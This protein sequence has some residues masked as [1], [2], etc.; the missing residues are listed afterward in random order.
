[1]RLVVLL[2]YFVLLALCVPLGFA[3]YENSRGLYDIIRVGSEQPPIMDNPAKLRETEALS[4][5]LSN[6]LGASRDAVLC[7]SEK[8]INGRIA[9]E[10]PVAAIHKCVQARA[11]DLCYTRL[12]LKGDVDATVFPIKHPYRE[13]LEGRQVIHMKASKQWMDKETGLKGLT[14]SSLGMLEEKLKQLSATK[15][16]EV[17]PYSEVIKALITRLEKFLDDQSANLSRDQAKEVENYLTKL[18]QA[19]A[20]VK[21]ADD[22]REVAEKQDTS[23]EDIKEILRRHQTMLKDKG[24]LALSPD[25]KRLVE[26][27]VIR[28]RCR[29]LPKPSDLPLDNKVI[30]GKA[31][32]RIMKSELII[33][34][35]DGTDKTFSNDYNDDEFVVKDRLEQVRSFVIVS[36]NNRTVDNYLKVTTKSEVSR[37]YK[38]KYPT[39]LKI[40]VKKEFDNLVSNGNLA[41]HFPTPAA[42]IKSLKEALDAYADLFP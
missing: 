11:A 1:M 17:D 41:E 27:M 37:N 40:W 31:N 38:E 12:V 35:K 18:R 30:V 24:D 28:F 42:R 15:S 4:R 39:F 34:M 33:R 25:F 2:K 26:G 8:G 10:S 16:M 7:V 36:D 6:S 20:M 23:A 13:Y 3:G 5:S 14:E 22:A 9:E 19:W 32:E 29:C 21:L